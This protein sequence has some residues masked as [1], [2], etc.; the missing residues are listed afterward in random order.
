MKKK[1]LITLLVVM[2]FLVSLVVHI[3]AQFVL[4]QFPLPPQL[5]LNGAT[6]TIWKGRL[7][8]AQWAQYQLGEVSWSIQPSKLLAGNLQAQVRFGRGSDLNVKGRGI[9]GYGVSG[10]YAENFVASMPVDTALEFAPNLP[11]P[12]D[13]TGQI[14]LSIKHFD[15][16]EPYCQ[17]GEGALVWNTD[18][19]GTPLAELN[20]GPVVADISCQDS[21]LTLKGNQQSEQV[22]SEFSLVLK[23]DSSYDTQAWFK[24]RQAFPSALQQQLKWLPAPE[25]NGRYPFSYQGRL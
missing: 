18:T 23:A 20:V 17:S 3:P 1:I 6:G 10:V 14:E 15:Y 13:L 24:P 19:I 11:V 22:E 5:S 4:S 7:V 12:L 8:S 21:T 9:V 16:A 2:A 25:D